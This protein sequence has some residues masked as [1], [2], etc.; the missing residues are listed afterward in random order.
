MSATDFKQVLALGIGNKFQEPP[1]TQPELFFD[2]GPVRDIVAIFFAGEIASRIELP[3]VLLR[4]SKI[5]TGEFAFFTGHQPGNTGWNKFATANE[6]GT[7]SSIPPK[8][9]GGALTATQRS[10]KAMTE[11][12]H[13]GHE[14][15]KGKR[16]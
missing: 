8:S 7:A 11:E 4:D 6:A 2:Y 3:Q 14:G 15:H 9:D 13:K 1:E 12:S 16:E 5:G 10:R